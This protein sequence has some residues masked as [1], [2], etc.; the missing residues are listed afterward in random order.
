M[1]LGHK[2][3]LLAS[4]LSYYSVQEDGYIKFS[5]ND[6]KKQ[7]DTKDVQYILQLQNESIVSIKNQLVEVNTNEWIELFVS[8][9]NKELSNSGV[10]IQ[11]KS[12]TSKK[13]LDFYESGK[14]DESD[15]AIKSFVINFDPMF[16]DTKVTD[17]I[18]FCNYLS[19]D[20]AIYWL[21]L[22]NDIN[23]FDMFC[24]YLNNQFEKLNFYKRPIITLHEDMSAGEKRQLFEISVKGYF[25]KNFNV[26]DNIDIEYS[27][28]IRK[29]IA[30]DNF[31]SFEVEIRSHTL[32]V[33]RT[34]D[35]IE[36]F[37]FEKGKLFFTEEIE[38]ILDDLKKKVDKK[39]KQLDQISFLTKHNFFRD[40][41]GLYRLLS[42]LGIIS[43]PFS[44]ILLFFKIGNIYIN[45]VATI[46]VILT[47]IPIINM[48]I[49]PQF[50]I[51]RFQWD[52][53][54]K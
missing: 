38:S 24:A 27:N 39:L 32:I 33:V 10:K 23:L 7:F 20:F 54:K 26:K 42:T 9:L 45:I 14:S 21:D 40:I 50:K 28:I 46:L 34:K 6:L 36:F 11:C 1:I 3:E 22:L 19:F 8:C 16:G 48:I 5:L 30:E 43:T 53:D 4:L 12:N 15:D 29:F 18:H 35:G 13:Q 47:Y 31:S 37:S 49:L 2:Y 44:A 17:V 41:Q 51:V 25:K 52:L